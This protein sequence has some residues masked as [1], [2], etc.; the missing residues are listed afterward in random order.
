MLSRV[1]GVE[2]KAEVV[3]HTHVYIN[4]NT[5]THTH[6]HMYTVHCILKEEMMTT[7]WRKEKIKSYRSSEKNSQTEKRL[8]VL[9]THN[10]QTMCV[11]CRLLFLLPPSHLISLSLSVSFFLFHPVFYSSTSSVLLLLL[12]YFFFYLLFLFCLHYD[13]NRIPRNLQNVAII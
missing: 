8:L 1:L 2:L 6:S 3:T 5:L 13:L 11:F 9:F 12:Y 4:I 7:E 10:H